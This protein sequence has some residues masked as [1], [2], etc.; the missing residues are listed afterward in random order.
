MFIKQLQSLQVSCTSSSTPLVW[1]LRCAHHCDVLCLSVR[2]L[3][4]SSSQRMKGKVKRTK[5]LKNFWRAFFVAIS[6]GKPF[7]LSRN[8]IYYIYQRYTFCLPTDNPVT[9]R[10]QFTAQNINRYDRRGSNII[11][12]QAHTSL[13]RNNKWKFTLMNKQATL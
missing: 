7:Y 8:W 3:L 11:C 1:H 12:K 9:C 2:Q 6:T 13:S 4:M 10:V 5:P